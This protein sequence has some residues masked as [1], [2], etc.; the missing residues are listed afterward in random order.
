MAK[1]QLVL[2]FYED[3]DTANVTV[4]KIKRWAKTG[5]GIELGVSAS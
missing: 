3:E 1:K 4:N 2:A 5:K